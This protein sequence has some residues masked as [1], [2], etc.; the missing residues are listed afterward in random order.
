MKSKI[1]CFNRALFLKS[2]AL[3][4]P[5]WGGFLLLLLVLVPGKL[6]LMLTSYKK[7]HVPMYTPEMDRGNLLRYLMDAMSLPFMLLL[8]FAAAVLFG[9]VLCSYLFTSK[10]T[11]MMHAFPVTRG[12]I[13]G[14]NVVTGLL[15]MIIPEF[16]TFLAS[17]MVCIGYG[18]TSVQYIG[19]WFLVLAG[20]TLLGYSMTLFSAM[21]TGQM[22]A[23]PLFVLGM[24]FLYPL[25]RYVSNL[26]LMCFSFGRMDY[27]IQ[28]DHTI[29]YFSPLYYLLREVNFVGDYHDENLYDYLVDIHLNGFEILKGYVL[30]SGILFIGA[31]LVYR[32]RALEKAGDLITVDFLKP[33]FRW[34]VG[35]C[36]GYLIVSY[37]DRF[38]ESVGIVMGKGIFLLLVLVI[39]TLCFWFAE[40]LIQKKFRIQYRRILREYAVFLVCL[41][42]CFGGLLARASYLEH[43]V[44]AL[45][46]VESVSLSYD[47]TFQKDG[48]HA[49]D[50]LALQ[51]KIQSMI[52]ALVEERKETNDLRY[53][54]IS[55][56][57][58]NGKTISKNY[59]ISIGE[60]GREI[61]SMLD[62]IQS[63]P[64]T[65]CEYIFGRAEPRED[66][67]YGELSINYEQNVRLTREQL[68]VIMQAVYEDILEG[69]LQKYMLSREDG[70]W[71]SKEEAYCT[72][73]YFTRNDYRGNDYGMDY[74]T[75]GPDCVHILD[76]LESLGLCN[77]D[78][79]LLISEY[80][81]YGIQ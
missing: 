24:N 48:A 35:L 54:Q 71:N 43:Y 74:V 39:G 79:M 78:Q 70:S 57:Q 22:F 29:R 59:P 56:R 46:D 26:V 5:L 12:E 76:A 75:V 65:F 58:K 42:L 73:L 49:A 2:A 50:L 55:V 69:N 34:G 81:G 21:L 72:Y 11:N 13:Y 66:Y 41:T 32:R 9:T 44:P 28:S 77:R 61:F 80:S 40:M 27:S 45:S 31:Y 33:V 8:V 14:T 4:W 62:R 16:F 37:L 1:F 23:V 6:W 38:L 25:V 63:E 15:F 18:I 20:V 67:A 30:V 51:K 10:S 53:V 64:E 19:Q 60:V 68:E 7:Y 3:F 17:V 36:C 52:P 47:F